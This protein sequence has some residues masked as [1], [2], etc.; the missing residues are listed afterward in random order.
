MKNPFQYGGIVKGPYFVDR[1]EELKELAREMENNSRVF[2][3]S[4][5]R[6]GKTCLLHCLGSTFEKSGMAWAY[7]DL[8]AF[9]D[10]RSFA[11]AM[12]SIPYRLVRTTLLYSRPSAAPRC[13]STGWYWP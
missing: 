8:N 2:L 13:L 5:R 6:F 12:T 7:I 4:P 9:P 1:D 10:L 11:G 3:V